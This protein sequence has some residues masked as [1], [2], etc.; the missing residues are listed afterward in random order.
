MSG[1]VREHQDTVGTYFGKVKDSYR[2]LM[3]NIGQLYAKFSEHQKEIEL[4]YGP[5]FHVLVQ[6]CVARFCFFCQQILFTG[7]R[8]T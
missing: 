7:S 8:R 4:E 1:L 5:K 3:T 6:R 2:E